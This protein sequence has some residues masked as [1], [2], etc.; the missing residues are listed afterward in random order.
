[1]PLTVVAGGRSLTA[2]EVLA[3]LVEPPLSTALTVTV[4]DLLVEG[5]VE[6]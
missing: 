2:S 4:N 5:P 1:M 6:A 3:E